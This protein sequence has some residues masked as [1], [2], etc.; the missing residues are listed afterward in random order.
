MSAQGASAA[1]R[2]TLDELVVLNEEI[3]SLVRAGVPL[4]PA[5]ADL[6][7]DLPGRLGRLAGAIAQRLEQGESLDRVLEDLGA[8]LPPVYRAVVSAGA[9]SGR[10]ASALETVSR[11]ARRVYELRQLAVAG[12]AYPLF[13]IA[14]AWVL[15]ACY[16]A[17]VAPDMLGLLEGHSGIAHWL[18]AHL[19]GWGGTAQYWGP[20]LPLLIVAL[21]VWWFFQVRRAS[22]LEPCAAGRLFGWLPWVRKAWQSFR[23]AAFTELLASLI[24]GGVPL[25]EALRSAAA[26]AT[27]KSLQRT[28][29]AYADALQQGRPLREATTRRLPAV[30]GWIVL[31]SP[32]AGMLVRSLRRGSQLYYDR[33]LRQ[34]ELARVCVPIVA[35]LLVGAS[36]VL[37]Y[38]LLVFGPWSAILA[39]LSEV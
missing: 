27:D 12:L 32:Q 36:V 28:A 18:L 5:L 35:T 15:L 26:T 7:K 14:L 39:R 10:L 16:S 24:E 29:L 19:T 38:A 21:A 11:Y 13:L 3:V 34:T 1:G 6:R 25:H 17:W 31:G 2:I 8:Q 4:A 22:V 9:K 20:A 37:I 33:A 30:F 23:F